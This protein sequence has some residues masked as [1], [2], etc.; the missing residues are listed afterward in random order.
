MGADGP[1]P[2]PSVLPPKK[3]TVRRLDRRLL[4]TLDEL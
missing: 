3:T 4:P 1:V 2:V